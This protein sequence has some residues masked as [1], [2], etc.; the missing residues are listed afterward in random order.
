MEK[1][2]ENN[3]DVVIVGGGPAGLAAAISAAETNPSL[4][5]CVVEKTD[6]IG[7]KL[8]ASGNGKG[9]LSNREC[10]SLEQVLDFFKRAGIA[11][12]EDEEGRI[13]P[14]SEEAKAVRDALV[15][16]A[17]GLG[18][19]VM[20]RTRISGA[21]ALENGNGFRVFIYDDKDNGHSDENGKEKEACGNTGDASDSAPALTCR[22]LLIATGGKSHAAY[23]STGDGF[24]FA[25]SLGHKVI[26]PVP[27]LT[28]IETRE[29][30]RALKGVRA[31]AEVALFEKNTLKYKE[32]G[33]VQ[34]R[35]DSLSGI[36]IM[37]LSSFLPTKEERKSFEN[38]R[39]T[40]NLMPD[41]SDEDLLAFLKSEAALPGSRARDLLT[42]V[43]KEPVAQYVLTAAGIDGNVVSADMK[44]AAIATIAKKLKCLTFRPK[45]RKGWKEAQVTRG[46]VALNQINKETM[47]S[48]LKKGLYFAG[49]VTDYNGICGGFN[50][51][52]AWLTGIKAGKSMAENFDEPD[53]SAAENCED[54]VAENCDDK[55]LENCDD[56][57]LG[58]CGKEKAETP[59]EVLSEA[60]TAPETPSEDE[61]APEVASDIEEEAAKAAPGVPSD[62][63]TAPAAL[64]D[65]GEEE[66]EAAAGADL[67][68][69]EEDICTVL[70]DTE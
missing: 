5:I 27:A 10:T 49:E 48:K 12:R 28:G 16:R 64:S 35:Q 55:A 25:R 67:E 9:N 58:N 38:C 33:E 56:K 61:T 17:N 63:E 37:N 3:F 15:K 51:H 41:I 60:E 8:C 36:C 54:K 57:A 2:I 70:P 20:L 24:I 45:G 59:A 21:K 31:K 1:N 68:K 43:V 65:A 46:G 19:R 69:R 11:V 13:Y 4:S 52:N 66:A 30:L 32:K 50:L 40:V 23:G 34:F 39:I 53:D 42:T 18:V 44:E 26:G 62:A 47:E 22:K 29:N 14:H 6:S 7:K